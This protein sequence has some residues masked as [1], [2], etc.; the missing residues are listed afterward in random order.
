[1]RGFRVYDKQT[2]RM[3]ETPADEGI[4][5]A[6]N[7]NLVLPDS[8]MTY[9]MD[10]YVRMDSTGLTDKNSKEI[11]EGDIVKYRYDKHYITA[12]VKELNEYGVFFNPIQGGGQFWSDLRQKKTIE[13][14]GDIYSNPELLTG[15][16]GERSDLPLE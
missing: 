6:G 12:L 11:Y 10:R 7:G 5:L 14:I 16:A 1:M 9:L 2:K 8:P 3:I 15:E 4:F 13:V